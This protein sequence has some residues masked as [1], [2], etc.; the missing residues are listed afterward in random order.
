M[1]YVRCGF[2]VI[3]IMA[4]CERLQLKRIVEEEESSG[5]CLIFL[6]IQWIYLFTSALRAPYSYP[7]SYFDCVKKVILIVSVY[8]PVAAPR[9]GLG[10]GD[11]SPPPPPPPTPQLSPR[12][13]FQF[14]QIRGEKL[15]EGGYVLEWDFNLL[16][17]HYE[18]FWYKPTYLNKPS[19]VNS[20]NEDK[21]NDGIAKTPSNFL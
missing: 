11:S 10:R 7:Y 6:K 12:S 18:S 16:I 20:K 4:K 3:Y 13:I 9:G 2:S 5:K 17:S 21:W 15:G 19:F 8:Q 14:V 1:N